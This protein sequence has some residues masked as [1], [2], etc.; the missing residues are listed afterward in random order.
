MM[1]PSMFGNLV[2]PRYPQ[3]EKKY[4]AS[5]QPDSKDELREYCVLTSK[6]FAGYSQMEVPTLKDHCLDIPKFLPR[7]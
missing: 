5:P 3:I 4:G 7:R 1:T 2:T 6:K